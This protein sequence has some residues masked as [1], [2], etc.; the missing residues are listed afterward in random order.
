MEKKR[1]AEI[2]DA[3]DGVGGQYSQV[4]AWGVGMGGRGRGVWL[5]SVERTL[6]AE[7]AQ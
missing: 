2:E 3:K 4:S 5:F 6:S 1:G 7:L